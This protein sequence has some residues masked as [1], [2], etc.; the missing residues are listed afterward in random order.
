MHR[1]YT[2]IAELTYRCPLRCAYCSNPVDRS[3]HEGTLE[4]AVW[5]RVL[6]EAEMLGVVQV[7]F[8][9]GEPLLF[10]DLERLVRRARALDLYT[11]LITSGLPYD[12]NCLG[13]LR[14]AGLDHVQLSFQGAHAD[15]AV[16]IAKVA[17][18]A[19]K[20]RA[21]ATIKELGFAFTVNVVVHRHNIDDIDAIVAL[22]ERLGADRLELAN[23]QYLGWALENRA[24][25]LPSREQIERARSAVAA[26]RARLGGRMEIVFV[27]PDYFSDRPRACMD[28]WGRR[29]IVISPSGLVLPC[30]AAHTIPGLSFDNVRD[31]ALALIWRGSAA[32]AA[33]RSDDWMPAPCRT[34]DERRR[35][36]GGCRCQAFHLT[37]DARATDPACVLAPSHRVVEQARREAEGRAGLLQLRH[38][39]ALDAKTPL[40]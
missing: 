10:H 3:H 23:A 19:T 15:D 30:H 38:R 6:T 34:C 35:D 18:F 9:G 24:S 27:L 2:L 12:A 8:T 17:A 5:E 26:A 14:D 25:L 1:P 32:L 21:A 33:F 20:E 31:R 28:G 40:D 36:F 22:G 4:T 13:R 39:R 37:G 7:H 11:N 16:A 29:Y